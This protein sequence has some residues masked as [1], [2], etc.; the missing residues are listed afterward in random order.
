MMKVVIADD[1]PLLRQV[2]RDKLEGSGRVN[3]V[4]EAANGQE[5]LT[6]VRQYS[7]D[8]LILDCEMP[9]M[10]GLTCLKA[11]QRQSGPA[12]LMFSSLTY[13]GAEVT[14]KALENG[15]VDF[16]AKPQAGTGRLSATLDVLMCKIDAIAMGKEKKSF[17]RLPTGDAVKKLPTSEITIIK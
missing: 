8:V 6:L 12:V 4:G 15:A 17:S 16:L 3:V 1:S 7:P 10:D 9:V 2:V 5:A 13:E 14:I 11:I